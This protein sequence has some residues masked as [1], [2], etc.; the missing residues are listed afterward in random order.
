MPSQKGIVTC[1]GVS[2]NTNGNQVVKFLGEG[3]YKDGHVRSSQDVKNTNC[4]KKQ[5][6][7]PRQKSEPERW[8]GI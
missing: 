4:S 5:D 1:E 6:P 8:T 7:F 3:E 2:R